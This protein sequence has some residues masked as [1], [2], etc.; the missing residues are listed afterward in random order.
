M[1]RPQDIEETN[2]GVKKIGD[3]KKIAEFSEQLEKVLEKTA[4][5]ESVEELSNWRP[6][7]DEAEGDI[8]KKTVDSAVIKENKLEEQS[9]GVKQD[10]KE[11]S[12]NA[13]EAGKKAA[14]KKDPEKEVAK[15]SEEV[16]KPFYSNIAKAFRSFEN[17]VYRNII[18]RFNPYYLDT[19][20][21]SVDMKSTGG[22]EYEMDVKV[23]DEQTRKDLKKEFEEPE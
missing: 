12:K 9:N 5:K 3:W 8:Q 4:D 7:T 2:S 19:E 1:M 14:E 18:L 11:A 23:P 16:A 6:K 13:A 15:A 17:F 22:G 10:L 20:D 21:F